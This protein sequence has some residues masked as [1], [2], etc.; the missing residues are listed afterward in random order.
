MSCNLCEDILCSECHDYDSITCTNC[1][2]NAHLNGTECECD[3]DHYFN[4]VT[5]TCDGCSIFCT[6]CT[7]GSFAE[8]ILCNGNYL[9]EN[10]CYDY[11]P[12]GYNISGTDCVLDTLNGFVFDL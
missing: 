11:C 5:E 3:T 2:T 10:L 1:K 6:T 4:N 8:C 9:I 12:T 7:G